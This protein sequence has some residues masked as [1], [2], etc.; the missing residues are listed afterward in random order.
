MSSAHRRVGYTLAK[1]IVEGWGR[2]GLRDLI[3]SHGDTASVLG[4]S[5]A[6]LELAWRDFVEERYLR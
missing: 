4:L 6:E 2:V 3:V 5:T 1:L